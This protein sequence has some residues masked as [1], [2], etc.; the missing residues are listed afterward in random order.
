VLGS[1]ERRDGSD[2]EGREMERRWNV[3]IDLA[4]R[5]RAGI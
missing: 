4:E 1:G 2:G 3:P 5:E